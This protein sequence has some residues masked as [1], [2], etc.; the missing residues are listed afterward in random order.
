MFRSRSLW[1]TSSHPWPSPKV[2]LL[3]GLQWS[4]G[5]RDWV[6]VSFAL[7]EATLVGPH[8]ANNDD[9]SFALDAS[10]SRLDRS[11]QLSACEVC[12]TSVLRR[13]TRKVVMLA[14]AGDDLKTCLGK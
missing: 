1:G 10:D 8:R 6:S 7:A 4:H 11:I 9:C 13:A 12:P 5:F 3:L 14:S 2:V